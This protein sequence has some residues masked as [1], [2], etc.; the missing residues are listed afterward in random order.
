MYALPRASPLLSSVVYLTLSSVKMGVGQLL[1]QPD[2][3]GLTLMDW[4]SRRSSTTASH[5]MQQPK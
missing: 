5:P 1:E 3:M 2:K 4:H